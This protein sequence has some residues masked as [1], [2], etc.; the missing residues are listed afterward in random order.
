M[1]EEV[2]PLSGDIAGLRLAIGKADGVA[3][4][5]GHSGRIRQLVRSLLAADASAF[6]CTRVMSQLHDDVVGRALFL[7]A[8]H[9]RLPPT[10]WCWLG[11]GSEGRMEQ[12]LLT[13]QDN[14][15]LYAASDAVEARALRQ[16]FLPF[17]QEVNA[18]LAECGLP[19][20][21]GEVM[22][23]NPKWCLSLDEW[24]ECFV[25]WIRT[26]EPDALL[27]ASIFFDFR[28]LAGDANLAASLRQV[29]VDLA[30]GNE[31]FL[32]MMAHN[33]LAAEPPLGRLRDFVLDADGLLDLKKFGSRIF[34]DAARILA[35][36]QGITTVG[37][38][39]RL[40]ALGQQ[41]DNHAAA[42]A[43]LA[44]QDL[45]L[46]S[47]VNDAADNRI[48]PVQLNEFDRG[49]LLESFRQARVLQRRLKSRFQIEN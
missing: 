27:N 2:L 4:L 33:A 18:A 34:V 42:Q 10:N 44:L 3:A 31:I 13:D 30:Q 15:L 1:L 7:V 14:G 32:R 40:R 24:R 35:L 49:V 22:A 39:Q 43:F 25:Q 19:L 8:R 16:T 6:W 9:H 20:C 47:Q 5:R 23:G 41:P 11:L 46:R 36:A 12:M 45:R 38:V 48:Y 29:L 21:D 28:A 17:A 37:T 26:P